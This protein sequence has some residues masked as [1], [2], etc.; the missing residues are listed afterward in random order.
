MTTIVATRTGLYSDSYCS[1]GTP[2]GTDKLYKVVCV[3]GEEYLC[4]MAGYLTEGLLLVNLLTKYALDEL[5]QLHL[6]KDGKSEMPEALRDPDWDTDLLVVTK[7]KRLVVIDNQLVPIPIN[8][9]AYA[10]GSGAHWALA[11]MD[12]GKSAR[13]AL[14]YACTRDPYSKAPIQVLTFRS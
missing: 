1:S 2:F 7:D 4:G 11:A 12:H 6:M 9:K 14:E 8:E 3:N 5:W 10:I 13:D